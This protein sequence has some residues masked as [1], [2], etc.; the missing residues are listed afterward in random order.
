[1]PDTICHATQGGLILLGPFMALI[2]RRIWIWI[3][4]LIGGLFGALPDLFGIYGH[5]VL[6]DHGS[7]YSSARQGAIANYLQYLPMYWL[8]LSLDKFTQGRGA[9]ITEEW[10][11]LEVLL[12]IVNLTVI[13]WF[14]KIWRTNKRPALPLVDNER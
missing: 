6:H 13:W 1:M 7:L 12:W 8:H 9:F 14:V 4:A 3:L 11:W 2:R 5:L 10:T